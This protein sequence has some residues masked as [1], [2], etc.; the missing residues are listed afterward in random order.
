MYFWAEK[1]ITTQKFEIALWGKIYPHA[2]DGECG[3]AMLACSAL[4]RA[5]RPL[6]L[7]S[8]S[9]VMKCMLNSSVDKLDG[10]R[11]RQLWFRPAKT[12]LDGIGWE[13]CSWLVAGATLPSGWVTRY[14]KN[15]K[16]WLRWQVEIGKRTLIRAVP[17]HT[18]FIYEQFNNMPWTIWVAL[19]KNTAW[20][21]GEH[22]R[23]QHWSNSVQL[24]PI[25]LANIT[26][27]INGHAGNLS[28]LVQQY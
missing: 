27:T 9:R 21:D 4:G 25:L 28:C 13:R 2:L 14:I 16:L 22:R 20:V 18:L 15:L 24:S 7:P 11:A 1:I 17:N 3:L 12:G 19:V 6:T 10:S 26:D 8:G 23:V 5:R